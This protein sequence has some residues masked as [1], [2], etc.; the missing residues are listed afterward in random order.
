MKTSVSAPTGGAHFDRS[1]GL[2]P[3]PVYVLNPGDFEHRDCGEIV[4]VTEENLL[5]CVSTDLAPPRSRFDLDVSRA[6]HCFHRVRVSRAF[7]D[8]AVS[9]VNSFQDEVSGVMRD[10][11][12][13]AKSCLRMKALF[14]VSLKVAESALDFLGF[15][16]RS[17]R[18]NP[19]ANADY[20]ARGPEKETKPRLPTDVP[21]HTPNVPREDQ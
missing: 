10:R 6:L 9:P 16:A 4:V 1:G 20:E 17:S 2:Q 21:P 11:C 8:E 13:L 18:V 15:R 3:R 19:C 5:G 12:R 14:E 7:I